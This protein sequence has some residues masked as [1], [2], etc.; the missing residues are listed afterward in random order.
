MASSSGFA[1]AGGG[2]GF[3]RLDIWGA[4][5][6]FS[7][8]RGAHGEAAV[9]QLCAVLSQGIGKGAFDREIDIFAERVIARAGVAFLANTDI[10]RAAGR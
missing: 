1:S 5:C 3:N 9:D 2:F 4:T 10:Q 8:A 7:P 6:T